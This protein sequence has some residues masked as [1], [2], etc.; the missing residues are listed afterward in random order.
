MRSVP[1]E[2]N[3]GASARHSL[4]GEPLQFEPIARRS[5]AAE[6]VRLIQNH[7]AARRLRAGDKL[8]A[9]RSLSEL[10][11]VSRTSVR[12]ALKRLEAL[13]IIEV[14]PG[15]GTFV[16]QTQ[17]PALQDSVVLGP[18][19][20]RSELLRVLEA[21]AAVDIAIVGLA[22]TRASAKDL[23]AISNYLRGSA[24]GPNA[25]RQRNAPD[26]GFETLIGRAAHNP[27]LLRMQEYVH[28]A[29]AKVWDRIG[30]IPRPADERLE[31]HRKILKALE[32]RD[33]EAA[34]R[35]MQEHLDIHHKIRLLSNG[36]TGA[37][38]GGDSA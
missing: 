9:E 22:A 1:T 31:Q 23:R 26:L 21:R 29:Y 15:K 32:S 11:G 5:V 28:T 7:L 13:G 2:K 38:G 6:V 30:F 27:Y 35:A 33:P 3:K 34:R 36:R 12:D 14:R 37:R 19:V 4:S 10:L 16:Q 20:P 17:Y 24:E 8:P 25:T 18:H